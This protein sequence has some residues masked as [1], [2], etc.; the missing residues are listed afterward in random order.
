[1]KKH[2]YCTIIALFFSAGIA[3]A[4]FSFDYEY[5]LYKNIEDFGIVIYPKKSI[6]PELE[7]YLESINFKPLEF[8]KAVMRLGPDGE[9]ATFM[10]PKDVQDKYSIKKFIILQVLDD[11]RLLVGIFDSELGLTIPPDKFLLDEARENIRETLNI[12]RGEN[13]FKKINQT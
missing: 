11:N 9:N 6:F 1:M 7:K 12:F 4:A 13:S 10:M 5:Q 3:F 2:L 8:G